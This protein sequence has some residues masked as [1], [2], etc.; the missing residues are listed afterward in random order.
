MDKNKDFLGPYYKFYS[1]GLIKLFADEKDETN[2]KLIVPES[3]ELLKYISTNNFPP[4]YKTIFKILLLLFDDSIYAN[5][6]KFI[7][8]TISVI[9][10][11]IIE[12]TATI[13]ELIY[14]NYFNN[15]AIIL[16][17]IRYIFEFTTE[18][19]P[20]QYYFNNYPDKV[21]VDNTR[22]FIHS[23][24]LLIGHMAYETVMNYFHANY[25]PPNFIDVIYDITNGNGNITSLFIRNIYIARENLKQIE[26]YLVDIKINNS[27][28]SLIK[29]NIDLINSS[30]E[31]FC[32]QIA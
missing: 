4:K 11:T 31:K 6:V 2:T 5:R 21:V 9:I 18:P 25:N 29:A 23:R 13:L 22:K 12:E 32:G 10:R 8:R 14:L 16:S 19:D 24:D 28:L 20:L 27:T 17:K 1:H 26:N 15:P 7:L 30:P 3:N